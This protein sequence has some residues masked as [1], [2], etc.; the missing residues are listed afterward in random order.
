MVVELDGLLHQAFAERAAPDDGAAV[1]VL[2]G[3]GKNL[4]CRGRTLVD[5]HNQ[6]NA[7][8]RASSVAAELLALRLAALRIDDKTVLGQEL[9]GYLYSRLQ[10]AACIASQVDGQIADVLL[11]QLGKRNQQFGVCV[12]AKVLDTDVA[13]LFVQHIGSC[14]ALG[15]NLATGHH[16]VANLL[17]AVTHNA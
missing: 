5:E 10:I 1:V 12:L 13:C 17:L 9:V 15:G 3:T 6:R 4:R 14:D 2:N 8:I 16:D 11:R 7:L